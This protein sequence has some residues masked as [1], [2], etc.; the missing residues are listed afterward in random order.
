MGIEGGVV[1]CMENEVAGGNGSKNAELFCEMRSGRG[2][3][4]RIAGW[5]PTLGVVRF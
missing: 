1:V 4:V 2:L 5:I 3:V